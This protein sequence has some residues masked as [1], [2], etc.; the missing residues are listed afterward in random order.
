[1]K[2]TEV[3]IA[4]MNRFKTLNDFSGV[5]YIKNGEKNIAIANFSF[6]EPEDKR[7]FRLS[8]LPAEPENIGMYNCLQQRITGVF[9]IDIY[10]PKGKGFDEADTKFKWI[11]KLFL[12]GTSFNGVDIEKV[13]RASEIEE[14]DKYRTVVR[15][16]FTADVNN[17]E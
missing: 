17:N 13:Y 8:F 1:M 11:S 12:E 16:N 10:T 9:Q 7:Y 3:R 14:D 2:D 6:V 5:P 4:L 15:V